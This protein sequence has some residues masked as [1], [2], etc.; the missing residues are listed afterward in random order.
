ML[1]WDHWKLVHYE[2][3][4]PQLFDLARPRG[5][6]RPGRPRDASGRGAGRAAEA[7]VDPRPGGGRPPR[8][9]R[10][11][12]AD[13][14]PRRRA[15]VARQDAPVLR[16]HA[17]VARSRGPGVSRGSMSNGD[18]ARRKRPGEPSGAIPRGESIDPT[19]HTALAVGSC[20]APGEWT[21]ETGPA[22]FMD[23]GS[24]VRAPPTAVS[25]GAYNTQGEERGLVQGA[26]TGRMDPRQGARLA[27]CLHPPGE[28]RTYQRAASAQGSG[29]GFGAQAAQ[30]GRAGVRTGT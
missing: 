12:G 28:A 13:R 25:G 4:E 30:A 10:P 23:S 21:P 2:G 19:G 8:V 24:S 14:T 9:R 20:V 1:R 29:Q 15:R 18:A 11:A 26:G 3:Y 6:R 27:P 7:G 17:H 22:V 16:L 5:A